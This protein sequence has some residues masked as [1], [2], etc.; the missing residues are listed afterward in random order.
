M[1]TD[2]IIREIQTIKAQLNRPP[3]AVEMSKATWMELKAT[4]PTVPSQVALPDT[5]YGLKVVIDNSVPEGKY[6]I[7]RPQIAR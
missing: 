1:I 2:D 5:L 6:R 7:V 3:S 4:F